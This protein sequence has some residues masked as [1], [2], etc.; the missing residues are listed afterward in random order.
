[1]YHRP[2]EGPMKTTTEGGLSQGTTTGWTLK[3]PRPPK[4]GDR[5]Q[6]SV[7]RERCSGPSRTEMV[8]QVVMFADLI[9]SHLAMYHFLLGR[10]YF[11]FTVCRP[12]A[13][14]FRETWTPG[15]KRHVTRAPEVSS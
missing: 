12:T 6:R 9:W 13:T 2:Y 4:S 11:L 15:A 10:C 14:V 8:S 1:M 3:R 5:W 7:A